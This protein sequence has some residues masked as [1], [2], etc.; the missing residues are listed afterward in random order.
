MCQI[1]YIYLLN[2]DGSFCIFNT[3]ILM[4]IW[5]REY[6]RIDATSIYGSFC[7]FNVG[8][9]MIVWSW[10]LQ[11]NSVCRMYVKEY[12]RILTIV[13][14]RDHCRIYATS[15]CGSFCTFNFGIL[16]FQLQ[17]FDGLC[18]TEIYRGIQFVECIEEYTT[19]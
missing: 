9:L 15:I 7:I 2:E 12:I 8:I 5:Y 18:N 6:F 16:H 1:E 14:Y 13:W 11:R 4:T 17:N 3:R 10:D 19:L